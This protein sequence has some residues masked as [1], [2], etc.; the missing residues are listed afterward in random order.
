MN[1]KIEG[2]ELVIRIPVNDP[3]EPSSTGKTLLVASTHGNKETDTL[4][5]GTK[6]IVSVNA[7][8]KKKKGL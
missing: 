8:I 1:V 7:Y 2:K 3:L 6:V 5:D 4:V